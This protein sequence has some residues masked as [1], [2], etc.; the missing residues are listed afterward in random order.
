VKVRWNYFAPPGFVSG[1]TGDGWRVLDAGTGRPVPDEADVTWA[2]EEAGLYEVLLRD[3]D[4]GLI[5]TPDGS[6]VEREVRAAWLRVV[7]PPGYAGAAVAPDVVV[8]D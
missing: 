2:D 5:L 6:E 3:A 4:G 1:G 7:P 8:G